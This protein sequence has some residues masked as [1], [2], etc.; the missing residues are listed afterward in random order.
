MKISVPCWPTYE[1]IGIPTFLV[2]FVS[3]WPCDMIVP[4]RQ[5]THLQW[6][7]MSI[8]KTWLTWTALSTRE[9]IPNRNFLLLQGEFCLQW[10]CIDVFSFV[11][12][13]LMDTPGSLRKLRTCSNAE[14]IQVSSQL[15]NPSS[16]E[17]ICIYLRV[18]NAR[19]AVNMGVK[20]LHARI[21]FF[22]SLFCLK[23]WHPFREDSWYDFDAIRIQR[24]R[25]SIIEL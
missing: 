10:E 24:Q 2:M 18:L 15:V 1:L 5:M 17:T 16:M 9:H 8:N 21:S 22:E 23:N 19:V 3:L 12:A 7:P 4:S 13:D 11:I 14:C 20:W 6:H 25:L